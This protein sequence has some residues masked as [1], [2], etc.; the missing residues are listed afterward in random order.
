MVLAVCNHSLLVHYTPNFLQLL[1]VH[2]IMCFESG[3]HTLFP[4][5]L[6]RCRS[7]TSIVSQVRDAGGAEAPRSLDGK[8][9]MSVDDSHYIGHIETNYFCQQQI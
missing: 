8:L 2:L 3:Q 7:S 5:L 1:Q 9:R 6:D 4:P